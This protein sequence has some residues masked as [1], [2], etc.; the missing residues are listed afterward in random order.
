MLVQELQM[1]GLEN[2]VLLC[3]HS[4][5]VCRFTVYL[6]IKHRPAGLLSAREGLL[7]RTGLWGL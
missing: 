4:T 7:E 2:D 5:V 6:N 1:L 3:I